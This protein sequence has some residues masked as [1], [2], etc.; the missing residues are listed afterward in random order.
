MFFVYKG[1]NYLKWDPR[2]NGGNGALACFTLITHH[3][4]ATT[5]S[6]YTIHR[7]MRS[8]HLYHYNSPP[9]PP[10]HEELPKYYYKS[11]PPPKHEEN[12]P[13]YNK[14]PPSPKKSLPPPY[15]YKS[16]PPWKKSPSIILLQVP[17]SSTK[18][19]RTSI[20]LLQI[21]TSTT[22]KGRTSTIL[23]NPWTLV[24]TFVSVCFHNVVCTYVALCDHIFNINL[25]KTHDIIF[26]PY[27]IILWWD[28][29]TILIHK[30][31]NLVCVWSRYIKYP[32]PLFNLTWIF[33]SDLYN[34]FVKVRFLLFFIATLCCIY[35]LSVSLRFH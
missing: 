7:S 28:I 20:L 12:P 10:K 17:T 19:G 8:I 16:S 25:T 4:H 3:R 26:C 5:T 29:Y 15:Y 32:P 9:S 21:A 2:V 18:E 30:G 22:K 31:I 14:S 33:I 34:F 24:I 11:L 13:F 6:A 1:C 23:G 27:T 35:L